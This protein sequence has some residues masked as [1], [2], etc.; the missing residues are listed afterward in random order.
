MITT[1]MTTITIVI[2]LYQVLE[3]QRQV[4]AK[5]RIQFHHGV[6]YEHIAV[7]VKRKHRWTS[8]KCHVPQKCLVLPRQFLGMIN[9]I[10]SKDM[11]IVIT[12]ARE[13]QV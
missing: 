1:T 3:W 8:R 9:T 7:N 12:P 10:D 4:I 6:V 2:E 11:D 5:T 13:I